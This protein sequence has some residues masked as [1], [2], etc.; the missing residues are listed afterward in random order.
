MRVLYTNLIF[1]EVN[2]KVNVMAKV[3][4]KPNGRDLVQFVTEKV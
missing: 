3:E 4:E 1:S 2:D